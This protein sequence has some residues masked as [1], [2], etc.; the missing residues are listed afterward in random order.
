MIRVAIL[1][2]DGTLVSEDMLDILCGIVGKQEASKRLNH[3]FVTGQRAGL[4]ALIKRIN[5]LRGVSLA[6]INQK[7][8]EAIY[9]MPGAIELCNFLRDHQVKTILVSGNII[10][11]LKYYQGILSIDHI[12]GSQPRMN[13]EC[14]EGMSEDDYLGP[15]FKLR[16]VQQILGAEG[17][18]AEECV[19]IGDSSADAELFELAGFAIAIHPKG[20]IEK[21]ADI[22]IGDDLRQAIPVLEPLVV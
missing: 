20:G 21:L 9:L 10:P 12:I 13:G 11:I 7:I 14:I 22:V 3:E 6:Q 17:I 19:A 4:S 1:D 16:S 5:L 18:K 8:S 15:N 2:F